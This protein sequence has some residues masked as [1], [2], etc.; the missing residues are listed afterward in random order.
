VQ[1]QRALDSRIII[2]QAKGVIAQSQGI[3]MQAA[4]DLIRRESRRRSVAL[5]AIAT[6]I[7]EGRAMIASPKRAKEPVE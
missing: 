7:V 3:D 1:L 6:Q 5:T 4:F 2:E